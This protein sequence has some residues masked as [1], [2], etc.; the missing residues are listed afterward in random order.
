MVHGRARP[1][2]FLESQITTEWR[3]VILEKADLHMLQDSTG[4]RPRHYKLGIPWKW[5]LYCMGEQLG[6]TERNIVWQ[7]FRS[8]TCQ[9][10]GR[11]NVDSVYRHQL[12][13]NLLPWLLAWIRQLF[14]LYD[15]TNTL[16]RTLPLEATWSPP[17]TH[18]LACVAKFSPPYLPVG[19]AAVDFGLAMI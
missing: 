3:P 6:S 13:L 5:T 12:H 18:A 19:S 4:S 8:M 17:V 7:V 9:A 2:R 1:V 14:T 15:R 11:T 10:G 16:P